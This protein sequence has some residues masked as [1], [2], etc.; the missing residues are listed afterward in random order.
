[1]E[2]FKIPGENQQDRK[3][4]LIGLATKVTILLG[5]MTVSFSEWWEWN[6][7]K[8]TKTVG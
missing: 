8:M 4:G 3:A 2:W 7:F 5:L 6:M 1:M